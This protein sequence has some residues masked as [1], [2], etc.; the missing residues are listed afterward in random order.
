[1]TDI[2]TT[3][4]FVCLA[5]SAL[6]ARFLR[7]GSFALRLLPLLP[8]V[9]AIVF[10]FNKVEA[11]M[12]AWLNATIGIIALLVIGVDGALRFKG[13]HPARG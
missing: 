4:V 9:P 1:M 8:I 2:S 5:A 12:P 13:S 3:G 6:L 10:G 11:P 7:H